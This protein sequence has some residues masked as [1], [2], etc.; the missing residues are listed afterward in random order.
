MADEQDLKLDL[1]SGA[2]SCLEICAVVQVMSYF[3]AED[4]GRDLT[5]LTP[6][7]EMN[8]YFMTHAEHE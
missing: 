6:N 1:K 2:F 3:L 5:K 7:A 8:R 4:G